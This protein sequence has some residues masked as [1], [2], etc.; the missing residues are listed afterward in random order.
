M[1]R[2]IEGK[3]RENCFNMKKREE[4]GKDAKGMTEE[5]K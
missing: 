5:K 1:A 3:E 4:G 2:G